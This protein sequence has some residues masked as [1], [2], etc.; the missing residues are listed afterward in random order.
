MGKN[1]FPN[2]AL[3]LGILAIVLFWFP[4]VNFIL[5]VLAI[6]FG[7]ISLQGEHRGRAITG[8]VLGI[9]SLVIEIILVVLAVSLFASMFA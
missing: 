6:I 1:G 4:V 9:I 5:A 7:A 2:A 3:I 8:L